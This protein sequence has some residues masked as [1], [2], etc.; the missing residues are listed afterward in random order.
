MYVLSTKGRGF[1]AYSQIFKGLKRSSQI[2]RD[3]DENVIKEQAYPILKSIIID[4][5]IT[6]E[7]CFS[8]EDSNGNFDFMKS[9]EVSRD[10]ADNIVPTGRTI[11]L[12]QCW[13]LVKVIKAITNASLE[14]VGT[15]ATRHFYEP[16]HVM[17]Y[18]KILNG[19]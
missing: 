18:I 17:I 14:Y 5:N 1:Y 16:E 4:E 11:P 7:D 13:K 6:C 8:F 19:I 3:S 15:A 9:I 10:F 12:E 2:L